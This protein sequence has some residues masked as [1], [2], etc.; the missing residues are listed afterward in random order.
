MQGV[1]IAK[2]AQNR[3]KSV[4][5]GPKTPKW[6]KSS[7]RRC[8]IP[9]GAGRPGSGPG[10][11][12]A[13]AHRPRCALRRGALR[14]ICAGGGDQAHPGGRDDLANEADDATPSGPA[15]LTLLVETAEGYANLCRLITLAR[16]GQEKGVAWLAK[17]DLAA[18]AK[19]LIGLSGCRRGEIPRLLAADKFERAMEIAQGYARVFGPDRFFVELQRHYLR[20][21]NRLLARLVV[22]ATRAGLDVVATGNTHYLHPRQREVHDV[23][24]CIRHHT[25]LEDAGDLLRPNAEYHLRS[26][27]EMAALFHDIPIALENSLHIAQRCAPAYDYLPAGPQMLPRFPVPGARPER[28]CPERSRRSRRG[29]SPDFYLRELCLRA[30]RHRYPNVPPRDLLA[31]ELAVIRQAGLA[32]YFLIVW[33]IVRFAR[34]VGIR[35]QGRGSAANSLVAYLL[36]ISPIDPVAC[37]LVFERFLSPERCG[38][39]DID[40]DFAADRREEVIQYVYRRYGETHAAMACTLVTFRARSAVR[41]VARV[42]GFPPALVERLTGAGPE[43]WD[44]LVEPPAEGACPEPVEGACPEP[45]EG[46]CLEPAEGACPEPAEGALDVGDADSVEE[47]RGLVEACGADLAGKR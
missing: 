45:A 8:P 40:V 1:N 35:C 44:E 7:P 14:A 29:R 15:H 6:I 47:S 10:D 19:G 4:K 43:Q 13:G 41:D 16:R 20:G 5:I 18:H 42:L 3:P 24:T 37:G 39:P 38:P 30:L 33:D 46:A 25:T 36:G 17:R 22:L 21:D 9:G 26:P 2:M 31:R 23:L 11:G 34:R 32:D 12:R 27:Q 28:T